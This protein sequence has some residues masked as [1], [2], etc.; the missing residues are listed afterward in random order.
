MAGPA[1][2]GAGAPGDDLAAADGFTAMPMRRQGPPEDAPEAADI[3]RT[4]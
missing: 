1:M 3:A 4:I 2:T